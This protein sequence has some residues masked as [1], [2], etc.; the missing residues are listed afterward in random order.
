MRVKLQPQ[1]SV[2]FATHRH[3]AIYITKRL[4]DPL[5]HARG[6]FAADTQLVVG[7]EMPA[8]CCNELRRRKLR[9]LNPF[10]ENFLQSVK[11]TNDG[12]V[13]YRLGHDL[14]Q[15]HR[16]EFGF[17]DLAVELVVQEQAHA[18]PHEEQ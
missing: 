8:T 14:N 5:H 11:I 4:L 13:L 12:A 6:R 10:A 9:P 15:H 3:V 17:F 7:A 16:R 18:S 2:V 1:N